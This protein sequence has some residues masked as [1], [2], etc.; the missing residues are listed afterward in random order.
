MWIKAVKMK[1]I[2]GVETEVTFW[3]LQSRL[4]WQSKLG[5]TT[6]INTI[7][8]GISGFYPGYGTSLPEGGATIITDNGDIEIAGKKI[9]GQPEIPADKAALIKYII[10]GNFFKILK[11]T[12]DQR[13]MITR[14]LGI[15]SSTL[16]DA[17]ENLKRLK[18]EEK[19]FDSNKNALSDDAIRLED[20]IDELGEI[21]KPTEVSAT[22]DNSWDINEAYNKLVADINESNRKVHSENNLLKEEYDMA[23]NSARSYNSADI[24]RAKWLIAEKK[25]KLEEIKSEG[26]RIKEA[27][28]YNCSACGQLVKVAD[29]SELANKLR[30][31]YKEVFDSIPE[32]EAGLARL[33]EEQSKAI[34]AVKEPQ[35]KMTQ[36]IPAGD[37]LLAKSQA[38]GIAYK[39]GNNTEYAQYQQD[40]AE[41]NQ[42][43]SRKQ[44]LESELKLKD[45]Q[46][47][48][49]MSKNLTKE[50][51]KYEKVKD[52]FNKMVEEKLKTTG[53]DIRL[54]KTLKNKS[55]KETFE[56]YDKEWNMYGAT[57]TG[58]ELYME[59]LIA[60]LFVEYLGLDFIL[61]DKWE[62]VWINLRSEV[63]KEIWDLQLIATEVTRDKAIKVM[64][65]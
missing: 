4:V 16:E 3:Q 27:Q 9:V 24:S 17:N 35:Y 15:D 64:K 25:K 42:K 6:I 43:I 18:Q 21:Q 13:L 49:L 50:I 38:V 39:D 40:L 60:K 54:F 26:N 62:S 32:V 8:A 51:K 37:T 58:N 56:I 1:W 65:I 59:V 22:P 48:E 46:L 5:K 31:E 34:A 36:P 14:V 12:G 61:F 63:L 55:V 57:S 20:Q 11:T 29:Q 30:L 2:H 41:Y 45:D 7:M 28:D 23:M 33:E 44:T 47:K 10:P 52:E 53:L 19:I